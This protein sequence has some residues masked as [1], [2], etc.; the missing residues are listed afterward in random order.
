MTDEKEVFIMLTNHIIAGAIITCS[1][2]IITGFSVN[3]GIAAPPAPSLKIAATAEQN[4]VTIGD[5]MVITLNFTN[6]TA[7]KMDIIKPILDIDSVSFQIKTTPLSN[8]G[9]SFVYSVVT[10]SV[11]EHNQAQMAKI[12]LAAGAEFKETFKIPAVTLGLWEITAY[13]KG[14]QSPISVEPLRINIIPPKSDKSDPPV[15][16]AGKPEKVKDGELLA[17]IETSKGV[18]KCRFFFNDTPNTAMNF[19][20]LAKEGF[21]DKLIFHRI[22]KGFMIQG[23]CPQGT[24]TGSPGYSIKA[25][26]N[27]NKHIKGTLS[28]ARSSNN[29]SAG[30]QFF[31]CHAQAQ[32]L[33]NKYTAFGQ[34]IEGLDTLDTIA[35]IPTITNTQ[36]EPSKPTENIFI[37]SITFEFRETPSKK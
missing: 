33:D 18:M 7:N 12:S 8:T 3:D 23:G 4:E 6:T 11:Y 24:G 26:F 1:L 35:N 17:R 27:A 19:I 10:P 32:N 9:K 28:M 2:L 21:Y 14:F 5:W 25:E 31:I 34:V 16:E 20:R 37:K 13:Y 36:G 29:D 30:S 15:G 22:I